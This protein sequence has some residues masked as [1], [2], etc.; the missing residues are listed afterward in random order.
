MRTYGKFNYIGCYTL[1]TKEVRKFLAILTHTIL[2]P[3]VTSALFF[4]V[5]HLSVG[6]L[7]QQAGH[8]SFWQFL[9]PGLIMM[10]VMQN[11]F[12]NLAT[13]IIGSKM[14]GSIVD[15]LMPPLAIWEIQIAYTCAGIT[16]GIIVSIASA[17]ALSLFSKITI[18]SLTY[19][20][21]FVAL[22]ATVMSL[23]G[24][25]AGICSEK[26]EH[27]AVV[28]NYFI[29]PLSFLSGTFYDVGTLSPIL[30]KIALYNPFFYMISGL[31]YALTG[32]S[33][34]DPFYGAI[35][36]LA[37]AIVLWI[38]LYKLLEAGYRLRT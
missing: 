20:I 35:G 28:T 1:Y 38:I 19:A 22:S 17:L 4:V 33:V 18:F 11:S 9:V 3:M 6:R 15:I 5:F 16:R 25:I 30:Q 13:S 37:L 7:K 26:W 36:L 14:L 27:V 12:Q 24:F 8:I 10:Q 23:I 29:I 32:Y 2:A 21:V 34:A 31:R